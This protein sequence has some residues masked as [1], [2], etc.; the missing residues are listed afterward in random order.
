MN[1]FVNCKF[2]ILYI[3]AIILFYYLIFLGLVLIINA[4]LSLHLQVNCLFC[5]HFIS[6]VFPFMLNIYVH[7]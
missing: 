2:D 4:H 3:I 7:V 5:T 6:L 1:T